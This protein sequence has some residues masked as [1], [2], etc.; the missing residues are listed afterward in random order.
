MTHNPT[1]LEVIYAE[2]YESLLLRLGR[3]Y[4]DIEMILILQHEGLSST[5]S[6]KVVEYVRKVN[7]I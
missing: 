7:G 2:M 3:P 6:I 5:E 4:A 1:E